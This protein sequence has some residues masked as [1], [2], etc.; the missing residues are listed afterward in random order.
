MVEAAGSSPKTDAVGHLRVP[1]TDSCLEP[2]A[3]PNGS[4]QPYVWTLPCADSSRVQQLFVPLA[5]GQIRPLSDMT[6]CLD[7]ANG[8]EGERLTVTGCT[9]P[10]TRLAQQFDLD[11]SGLRTRAVSGGIRRCVQA[12]N[13]GARVTQRVCVNGMAEQQ[14][15]FEPVPVP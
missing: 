3:I 6:R 2:D 1:S 9:A 10:P 7:A 14:W 13:D 15:V 4:N 12:G 5:N 11:S 8:D